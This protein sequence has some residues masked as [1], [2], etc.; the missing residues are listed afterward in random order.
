MSQMF[1]TILDRWDIT[2][3]ELTEIVDANPSLRG[4]MMGYVSEYK[5]RQHVA[6]ISGVHGIKKYDDHDRTKKGDIS[7]IYHREEIRIEVKSLQTNLVRQ[8]GP[9]EWIG[10]FQ[11]DASDRREIDLPNGT[12]VNTTCL[13]VGEFDIVAVNLFAFGNRWRYA[14]AL[15]SDLPHPKAG[16][17]YDDET[18]QYLISSNIKISYPL[19]PPFTSNLKDLLD[20]LTC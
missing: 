8:I 3:E 9:D 10:T 19:Q 7:L 17:K 1:D 13:A 12:T 11:C 14:F 20:E 5:V 6:Q 4:F 18:A 15:N 2:A 16:K